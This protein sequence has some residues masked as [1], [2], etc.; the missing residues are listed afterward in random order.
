MCLCVVV[1]MVA[2]DSVSLEGCQ[3]G[4]L[5]SWALEWTAPAAVCIVKQGLRC[6]NQATTA[7][8]QICPPLPLLSS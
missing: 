6:D 2:W 1:V 7:L 5:I 4:S 3:H 8:T